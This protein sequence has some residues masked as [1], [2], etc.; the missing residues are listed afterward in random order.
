M[1][2]WLAPIRRF[3]LVYLNALERHLDRND[4]FPISKGNKERNDVG[5]IA[6]VKKEKRNEN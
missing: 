3:W 1:D 2:T 5:Q 6:N 4:P